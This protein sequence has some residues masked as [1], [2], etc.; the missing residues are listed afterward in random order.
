MGTR[1]S[2]EKIFTE[3]NEM[4]K[5]R[6]RKIKEDHNRKEE[7]NAKDKELKV[8]EFPKLALKHGILLNLPILSKLYTYVLI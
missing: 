2:S 7:A 4:E 1:L 3:S 6:Q 5:K 8:A